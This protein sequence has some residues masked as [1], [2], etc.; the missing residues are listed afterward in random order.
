MQIRQG[1]PLVTV[2]LPAYNAARTIGRA[3]DS[4]LAQT[5]RTIE[6]IVVDDCS[7][8]DTARIVAAYLDNRIRLLRLPRNLGAA[9]ALNPAI[10]IARGEYLAFL[11]ADDEWLPEKLAVQVPALRKNPRATMVNCGRRCVDHCG[12]VVI[13][14]GTPPSGVVKGDLWRN[15]LADPHVAKPCI[16]ARTSAL[17]EVGPFDPTLR[18]GG[19]QDMWIRLAMAGEVEFVP[20]ILAVTHETPR[21]VTKTFATR[22]DQYVLPMVRRHIESRRHDLS[23][24]QIRHILAVRYTALG[25]NLYQNGII[26]RGSLLLIKAILLRHRI[27]ENLLYLVAASPFAQAV[28]NWLRSATARRRASPLGR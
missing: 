10:D 21:S 15:L 6:V 14:P 16:V 11:D 19:D 4:A 8:D 20:D 2:V 26:V 1:Q 18:T 5:Y 24:D 3:L 27:G 25:R 13:D 23:R 22:A 28:K 7:E 12:R 17:H 9:G